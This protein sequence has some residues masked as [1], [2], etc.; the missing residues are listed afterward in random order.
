MVSLDRIKSIIPGRE[1]EV[2]LRR[3][4]A[5]TTSGCIEEAME[6]IFRMR[7][8]CQQSR[9]RRLGSQEAGSLGQSNQVDLEVGVS[10]RLTLDLIY[11]HPG[12]TPSIR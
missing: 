12:S 9:D 8:E 1:E 7:R 2:S 3:I 6:G 5:T 4:T 11:E 10:S